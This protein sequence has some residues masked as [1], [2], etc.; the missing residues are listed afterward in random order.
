MHDD[1]SPARVGRHEYQLDLRSP[2]RAK[3][4]EPTPQIGASSCPNHL[5]HPVE[6][7]SCNDYDYVCGDPVNGFDLTGT[8][9]RWNHAHHCAVAGGKAIGSGARAAAETAWKYRD[10]IALGAVLVGGVACGGVCTA[11]FYAGFALA[12]A[13]TANACA[14]GEGTSCAVGAASLATG[15]AGRALTREY[16]RHWVAVQPPELGA[17]RGTRSNEMSQVR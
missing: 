6:G 2:H 10:E 13:S 1:P 16:P 15:G 8:H 3:R 7:G 11:A 17:S 9:C 14:Q 5:S 12:S 4:T